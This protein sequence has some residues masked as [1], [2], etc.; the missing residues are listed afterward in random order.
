M[1]KCVS[2]LLNFSGK[3]RNQLLRFFLVYGGG[4][5]VREKERER[6][7]LVDALV[8]HIIKASKSVII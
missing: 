3:E 4:E 6:E 7:R 1:S 2:G 8:E 5:K